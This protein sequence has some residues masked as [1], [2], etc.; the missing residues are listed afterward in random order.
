MKVAEIKPVTHRP[1]APIWIKK[2]KT[3]FGFKEIL[4]NAMKGVQK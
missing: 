2:N 4:E 1:P 3:E